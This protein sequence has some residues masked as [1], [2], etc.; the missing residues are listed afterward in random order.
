MLSIF[1]ELF[2]SSDK[3][4]SVETAST[5]DRSSDKYNLR[6]TIS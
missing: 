6:E 1:T 4:E 3:T 2:G 5:Q